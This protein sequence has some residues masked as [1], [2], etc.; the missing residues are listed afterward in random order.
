MSGLYRFRFEIKCICVSHADAMVKRATSLV[1]RLKDINIPA[2]KLL[3]QL[4]GTWAGIQAVKQLEAQD[5][6]CQVAH[7]YTF[8]QAVAAVKAAAS[9]LVLNATHVNLWYDRHPGAIRDPQVLDLL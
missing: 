7:V 6:N 8:A 9:V 3:V 4:P 1:K 5:I 2:S